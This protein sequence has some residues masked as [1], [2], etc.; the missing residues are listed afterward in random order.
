VGSI[1]VMVLVLIASVVGI[2]SRQRRLQ[3]LQLNPPQ[4]VLEVCTDSQWD[5]PP[6]PATELH[7]ITRPSVSPE[8]ETNELLG[9]TE[10]EIDEDEDDE[11]DDEEDAPTVVE[12][13]IASIMN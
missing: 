13:P 6:S 3:A 9:S 10:E 7:D 11:D 1:S 2:R 8:P 4:H 5:P 12:V